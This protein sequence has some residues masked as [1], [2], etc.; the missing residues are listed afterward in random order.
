[1]KRLRYSFKPFVGKR[2]EPL[3]GEATPYVRITKN[4][5]YL[6]RQA[7]EQLG[8]R[9]CRVAFLYDTEA[10]ALKIERREPGDKYKELG[11][12]WKVGFAPATVTAQLHRQ[13]MPLG[14][15]AD[16]GDGIYKLIKE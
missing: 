9:P 7:C 4:G 8:K 16:Q 14:T 1:M 2:L 15:Y 12:S 10:K 5:A 11:S 3:H 13:G 6:N